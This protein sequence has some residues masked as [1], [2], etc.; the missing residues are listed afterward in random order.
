LGSSV[1][2]ATGVAQS[3]KLLGTNNVVVVNFGEGTSNLGVVHESINLAAALT[4]PVIYVC[5]NNQ[6]AMATSA[7]ES[8]KCT[9]VADRAV[10]YGIPGVQVDGNDVIEVHAAVQTAIARARRGEGPTLI[11]ARTYRVSGHRAGDQSTYQDQ[12]EKRRWLDR[13]P[14]ILLQRRL[15][16]M[17]LMDA[18]ELESINSKIRI[19]LES[20]IAEADQDQDATDDALGIDAIFAPVKYEGTSS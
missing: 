14:L 2:I 11:D 15:T 13:D 1:G 19:Q 12:E 10:G 4:L 17:S 3:L 8:M 16:A 20:A 7:K 9:S 6:Y 18:A 5:Q